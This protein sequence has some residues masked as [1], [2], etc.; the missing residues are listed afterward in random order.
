MTA[1]IAKQTNDCPSVELA[2]VHE[3]QHKK[4]Q[5]QQQDA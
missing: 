3:H 4:Q 2:A 5:K 1:Q